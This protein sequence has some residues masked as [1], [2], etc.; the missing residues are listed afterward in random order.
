MIKNYRKGMTLLKNKKR[1]HFSATV[2]GFDM[3]KEITGER[4][5][6][7]YLRN[8]GSDTHNFDFGWIT[9]TK[10]MREK[11][12]L[13]QKWDWIRFDARIPDK[14][15]YADVMP[16]K[17]EF[18]NPT[19]AFLT[20]LDN[21]IKPVSKAKVMTMIDKF[22]AEKDKAKRDKELAQERNKLPFRF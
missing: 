5:P 20:K 17:T 14:P 1:E 2:I 22:I 11:L 12:G 15:R 3:F 7:V 4:R 13:L 8:I 16:S 21:R 9:Y 19:K 6:I 18:K 10:E